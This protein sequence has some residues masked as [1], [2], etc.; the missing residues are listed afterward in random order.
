MTLEEEVLKRIKPSKEDEEKLREK[1]RVVLDRLKGYEAEIEGSFRKGTWLKGD[2]DIDIFVFF[3]KEVGKEYLKEKALKELIDKVKDLNYTIAYAE[4]PYLIVYVDNIEIDIVPALKI[5]KGEDAITAADRTPFHSN[6]VQEK[7]D[8]RGKDEVRLLKRFMKGIGV[9]GAEIKVKGFSGYVAELLV[10]YYG[11]FKEVIKNASKWKPPVYIEL[12][13]PRKEFTEPLIIPDPVDPK[14]N[15]SSAVSLKSLA[16]FSLAS[17]FYLQ[18]PTLEFF[19]PRFPGKQMIIGDVLLVKIRFHEKTVEDIIWG[20][21]W[22]NVEKL[23]TLLT[24]V[25]YKLIDISAWGTQEEVTIGIQLESKSIG[26]YFVNIGPYFY[27]DNVEEFVKKNDIVWIGEDGRLY[28][29]KRRKYKIEN[30]IENNLFFKQ[31]FSYELQWL[32]KEVDDPWINLFLRKTPFWL[33]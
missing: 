28:S 9:Y 32:D 21:V 24:K 30:I 17:K 6:F 15:A 20:Q 16:T 23:R 27:F 19:Y 1:A 10:I 13:K 29:V 4:H 5:E 2:T 26:D 12:V 18:N 7:L 33:K 3:P 14:R 8:E 31:K 25:G 11:S 22:R